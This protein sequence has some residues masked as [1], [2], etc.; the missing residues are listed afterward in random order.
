MQDAKRTSNFRVCEASQ[1]APAAGAT[2]GA[3][4]AQRLDKHEFQETIEDKRTARPIGKRFVAQRRQER[5]RT[6]CLDLITLW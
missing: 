2:V 4:I 6:A 3:T 1:R 5:T